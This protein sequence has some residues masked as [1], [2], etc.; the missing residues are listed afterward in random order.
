MNSYIYNFHKKIKNPPFSLKVIDGDRAYKHA[1]ILAIIKKIIF[2]FHKNGI[3]KGSRVAIISKNESYFLFILYA[4]FYS[5]AIPVSIDCYHD[6]KI[7][8]ELIKKEPF[9][10]TDRKIRNY[11]GKLID[12]SD[13][14]EEISKTEN[15]DDK[16]FNQII[17]ENHLSEAEENDPFI[18]LCS[19]GT[20]GLPKKVILSE[21]NILWA[22][23]EYARLY[24]FK[25]NNS[26]A[27]IVPTH[28]SLGILACGIIPFY[29]KKTIFIND[30]HNISECLEKIDEFKIN[31]L[32]ATP[33]IYN[34]M[35][36]CDL[37][38]YDFS[39]LK[40]CDSGGQILPISIIKKFAEHTGVYITEGYGLTETSSLTHFLVKDK[41][42]KLRLGSMGKPCR[43]V[44]CRIIDENCKDVDF[45]VPG[46]LLVNGPQNMLSYD[47]KEENKKVFMNNGWFD[48]GDIVYKDKEDFYYFV[49]RKIDL[50]DYR[51]IDSKTIRDIE[52]ILYSL[53]IIE[54]CAVL[55][56]K[57]EKLMIFI[58]PYTSGADYEKIK[59][60]ISDNLPKTRFDIQ[61][62][63]VDFIPRTSTHKV[64]R[65][66]L[67]ANY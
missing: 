4:L 38:K 19:S 55:V 66:I 40:V 34:L 9:L 20:T 53:E 39:H 57:N 35:N 47:E 58:K 44:K 43:N 33:T 22:D 67:R 26:I 16:L 63:L 14:K 21:K 3:K 50:L 32:P 54:E 51:F 25:K 8:D 59:K 6:D 62:K 30:G 36:R 13:L 15:I 7:V 64:K 46:K 12:I 56:M 48:T 61:I 1:D 2:I 23:K 60:I 52:E 10:I 45:F 37:N 31:I 49:S 27:F 17:T 29:H 41:T 42:G 24:N 65:N 11:S 18:I 5:K 28:Y